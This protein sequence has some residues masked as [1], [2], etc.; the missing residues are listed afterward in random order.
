MANPTAPP[1]AGTPAER[2]LISVSSEPHPFAKAPQRHLGHQG[3]SARRLGSTAAALIAAMAAGS[4][5]GSGLL[6]VA[7]STSP[8]HL[9]F[10]CPSLLGGPGASGT[11]AACTVLAP[12]DSGPRPAADWRTDAHNGQ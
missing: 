12:D 6:I 9:P 4:G 11:T 8:P 3:T 2:P 7:A 10:H 1:A 5:L